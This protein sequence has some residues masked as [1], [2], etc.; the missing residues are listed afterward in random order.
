MSR[1]ALMQGDTV[2]TVVAAA[3]QPPAVPQGQWRQAVDAVGPGHVWT[4]SGWQ[5]PGGAVP[6]RVTMRQARLALHGAGLLDDVEAAIDAISDADDR[7]AAR[8][9]WDHSQEV[10]RN[11][12]LV[13]QLAPA[14]G[15]T[16][17]Q[18]DALFVSAATL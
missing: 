13:A 7:A 1:W 11:N 4:G 6:Q 10:V 8:I 12:G 16:D 17:V 5:A 14:L 2:L 18:I 9:T 15:L 3:D